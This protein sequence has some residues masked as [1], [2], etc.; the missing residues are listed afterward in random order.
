V[1]Y[2]TP[3]INTENLLNVNAGNFEEIALQVFHYQYRYNTLY[4]E[5]CDALHTDVATVKRLTQIPFLP[6]SFF[7]THAV[8]SHPGSET[9]EPALVFESSG[10]TGETPSRH[11]IL[12]AGIYERS[13]LEGF[14]EFYGDSQ[15]YTILALLPSYLERKNA[16]LVHMAM[17]LMEKSGQPGNG[18]YI[19]E[20]AQLHSVLARLEQSRQKV[21]LL[22]VTFALL[23][24]AAA[25]PMPLANT[26]VMET[27]GMKGRREELTRSEVHDILKHQWQIKEVH[28]EYGMTELLSQ[29]YA[30]AGGIF[31]PAATMRVLVRDINDPLDVKETGTGAMNIVDLANINSCSFIETEDIGHINS[32]GTFE[33]LG[34]MDHSALRGCSLMAV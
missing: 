3:L 17:T 23:D 13:L 27:G 5:Y 28:S 20:W 16:S 14:K 34:R 2:N 30:T 29:A 1:L 4:K 12:D 6:I 24:F 25:Y 32:D 11:Y 22:G 9:K 31:R 15:Q 10:T 26:I 18:F 8:L 21:L 7:K 19:N 33:V